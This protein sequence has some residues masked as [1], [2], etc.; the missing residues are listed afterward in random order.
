MRIK[1]IC[2][3][4]LF[5]LERNNEVEWSKSFSF[6]VTNFNSL[7]LIDIKEHIKSFYGGM[8]SFGDLVLY[9]N[10]KINF[11]DNS[12]LDQLR[13]YLFFLVTK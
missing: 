7:K 2:L 10:G 8:G 9:N 6:I 13:K 3:E 1:E 5:L 11:I 4:I 12:R